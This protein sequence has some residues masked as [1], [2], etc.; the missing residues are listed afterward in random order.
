MTH[1]VKPPRGA[2]KLTDHRPDG[3]WQ[4]D[5]ANCGFHHPR[6]PFVSTRTD[7]EEAKRWHRCP[8]EEVER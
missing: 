1:R 8:V 5:C 6:A 2:V 7:A 4:V 3:G